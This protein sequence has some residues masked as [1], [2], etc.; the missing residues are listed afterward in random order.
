MSPDYPS[1]LL[2]ISEEMTQGPNPGVVASYIP[3]LGKVSKEHLGVCLQ[4]VSGEKHQAGDA[5]L[6]FSIQSIAKVFSLSLAYQL[7][8]EKI[9]QRLGVEPSGNAF[10]SLVQL[11][12]ENGIPRNPFINAGA[13]VVCD[14]LC[15]ELE[16][17]K[18]DLLSFVRKAAGSI[19]IDYSPRIA[20]SEASQGYRNF[21]LVNFLR[22][23]NNL[24]NPPEQV[25]DL[26]FHL[27]SI[28]MSC[29]ELAQAFLYLANGGVQPMTTER[30]IGLGKTKRVNA[31]MQ[32][33]GFYD[34]AGEFAYRVGL[35]G[36]SG[37]GGGI[38]AV[39]PGEYAIAV[40]SPALNEHGN[41]HRG[42]RFLELFTT[43]TQA[44]IF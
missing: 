13:I 40:W 21:A 9:W 41:S 35:P 15:S 33:C 1:L 36:K 30:I 7:K 8:G 44:S 28:E 20:A 25:I 6:P 19:A 11:E 3:E 29:E 12:Y 43:Q 26:Y 22:S 31:I 24:L 16:N 34:Q 37:V 10:N 23:F 32:T 14:V 4:L 39:L 42:M 27:S 18:A 2:A 17:P 38:A 5:Q